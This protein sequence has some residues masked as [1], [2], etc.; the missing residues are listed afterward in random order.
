[1]AKRT[2]E[3]IDPD[4]DNFKVKKK[5]KLAPNNCFKVSSHQKEIDMIIFL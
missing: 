1:M 5:K 4:L 3:N 2:K